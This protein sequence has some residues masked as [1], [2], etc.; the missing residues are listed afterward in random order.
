MRRVYNL[1]MF[2]DDLIAGTT[3]ALVALPLALAFGL[4][5]G[6]G[7][8]AGLYSAIIAGLVASLFGGSR[9]QITGPTGGM[10]AVLVFV[11]SQYGIEKALIAGLLAGIIQIL[12]GLGKLGKLIK[13]IPFTVTTGF[14]IGIAIVIMLSQQENALSAP[15]VVLATIIASFGIRKISPKIPASLVT[16]VGVSLAVHYLGLP[17]AKLGAIPSTLPMPHLPHLALIDIK[18]LVKPAFVLAMLGSIESLLSAVV[19]DGMTVD[20]KHDSNRELIGQGLGNLAAPLFGGVAATGAIARTAVNIG[21]GGRT[22]IAGVI[23]SLVILALM[24]TLAPLAAQIPLAVLAGVLIVAAVRM[25]EWENIVL[26]YRSSQAALAVMGITLAVTILV[27]LVT[28]VEIGLLAGAVLFIHRMS[29][30]GVYRDDSLIN[31]TDSCEITPEVDSRIICF[32]MD[33]PLFFGAA[34]KFV[35]TVTAHPDMRFLILRM[36]RVPLIDTTG[37]VAL[38]TMHRQLKRQGCELLISGLKDNL[39]KRLQT[40]GL[41]DELGEENIFEWTRDA[42]ISAQQRLAPPEDQRVPFPSISPLSQA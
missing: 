16:V 24:L 26:I 12:F 9:L 38:Q 11:V 6:V 4:A 37:V 10:T 30:L 32:R 18:E 20:E 2:R 25:V 39:A 27:D 3:V 35:Q 23:H 19:A 13:F 34:E 31:E 15:L 29:E 22:R 5:S 1:K 28:A 7:A 42:I 8:A 17:V 21:A 41:L 33:G 14:T 40:T 36:R